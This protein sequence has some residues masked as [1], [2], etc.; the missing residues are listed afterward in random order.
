MNAL[1][2]NEPARYFKKAPTTDGGQM[3]LTADMLRILV[4][5]DEKRDIQEIGRVLGMAPAQLQ[6]NLARLLDIG[7]VVPVK[8]GPPCYSP[9]FIDIIVQHLA[10][11]VGP[12]AQ[13]IV[14]DVLADLNISD[15]RIPVGMAAE[16]VSTLSNE[17]PDEMQQIQFKKAM[18]ELL[19]RPN[20]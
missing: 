8:R 7:L 9:K 15:K 10:H 1:F 6:K 16:V 19:S 5:I 2:D 17:I 12:M 18:I 13:I 11:S 20:K 3:S 4:A 14:E